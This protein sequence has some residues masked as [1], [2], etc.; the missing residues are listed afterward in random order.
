LVLPSSSEIINNI[1]SQLDD[2][3]GI[4]EAKIRNQLPNINDTIWNE[5]KGTILSKIDKLHF[6]AYIRVCKDF[7]EFQILKS[8]LAISI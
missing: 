3:K 7:K 5:M 8:L 2:L 4:L 1:T 6:H